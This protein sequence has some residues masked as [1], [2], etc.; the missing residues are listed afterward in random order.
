MKA[1]FIGLLLSCSGIALAGQARVEDAAAAC[2][3]LMTQAECSQHRKTLAGLQEPVA[4]LAYLEQ[5]LAMLH[6]RESMCG[7]G[8]QRLALA[9]AQYR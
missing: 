4:R 8:A 7:L 5:H 9:R 6:E 2:S 1:V 3:L